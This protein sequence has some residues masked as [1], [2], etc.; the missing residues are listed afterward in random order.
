MG[1]S[2]QISIDISWN[3]ISHEGAVAISEC[4]K[5]NSTLQHLNISTNEID[6]SGMNEIFTSIIKNTV[7][8]KLDESQNSISNFETIIN[9]IKSNST[10][11]GLSISVPHVG[12]RTI[13]SDDVFFN[14]RF[15]STGYHR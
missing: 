8:L 5:Y 2:S 15:C 3:M 11:L 10:L 1:N 7:L 14:G 13:S 12:G 6:T 4:L 9:C